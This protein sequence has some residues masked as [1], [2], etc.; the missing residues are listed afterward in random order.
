[1]SISFEI[2]EGENYFIG[3]YQGLITDKSILLAWSEYLNSDQWQPGLHEL[4]DLSGADMSQVTGEGLRRLA[5]LVNS[6]YHDKEVSSVRVAVYAP[7]PYLYGLT[8]MYRAMTLDLREN[9]ELFRD[10]ADAIQ[11]L[12]SSECFEQKGWF[13]D[14]YAAYGR[15]NVI[16]R[17]NYVFV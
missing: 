4:S 15:M 17:I 8:R 5:K 9:V 3:N 14:A 2:V 16:D 12:I 11:W 6:F 7:T 13:P 10:K 1:M